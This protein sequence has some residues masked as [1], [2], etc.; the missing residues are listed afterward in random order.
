[1]PTTSIRSSGL[2]NDPRCRSDSLLDDHVFTVFDQTGH[3]KAYAEPPYARLVVSQIISKT[4]L[5][6]SLSVLPL[7]D[8]G[9]TPL[10]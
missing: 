5:D 6:R 3:R 9:L 10:P 1:M 7:C 2:T 4:C 8:L